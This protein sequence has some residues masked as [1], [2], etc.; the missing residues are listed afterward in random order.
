M[1]ASSFVDFHRRRSSKGLSVTPSSIPVHAMP[2]GV[3]FGVAAYSVY[4]FGD[5]FIKSL[6]I[7]ASP[8][9]IAFWTALFSIV[10]VILTK[11][12]SERIVEV[13][14]CTAPKRL[15]VRGM[16]SFVS[17][18]CVI[19]AFTHIPFAETYALVFMTPIFSTVLSVLILKEKMTRGRWIGLVLGFIGVMLV[20]RPGF[21]ELQLGHLAAILASVIASVVSILL[22]QVSQV[23]KRITIVGYAVG[24]ALVLNGIILV[25]TGLPFLPTPQQL[26]VLATVG[27]IGGFGNVLII[28]AAKNAPM[29][30]V[31]PT[32]YIQIF[33]AVTLGA[34]VFSEFPGPFTLGGLLVM[35]FAGYLCFPSG[36]NRGPVG[37]FAFLF[38]PRRPR[39]I[40]ADAMPD[41][42]QVD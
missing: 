24:Y 25:S 2:V 37:G 39:R 23:E 38:G 34:L 6:G 14:K 32:Q 17:V 35:A 30:W 33:W 8:F 27:I 41:K 4:S 26:L 36:G 20:V 18:L 12:R 29:A 3:Y 16:L 9:M 21:R 19:Y 22:R 42:D 1:S 7:G 11:P 5:A 15:N 40:G 31:A 28:M 13:F 10:P